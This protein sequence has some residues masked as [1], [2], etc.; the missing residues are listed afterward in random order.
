LSS[1]IWGKDKN[2]ISLSASKSKNEAILRLDTGDY[3]EIPSEA[4]VLGSPVV[5]KQLS[6]NE[7]SPSMFLKQEFNHSYSRSMEF[8]SSPLINKQPLSKNVKDPNEI[9]NKILG[10]SENI[11][12]SIRDEEE[13]KDSKMVSQVNPNIDIDE[14]NNDIKEIHKY[15]EHKKDV[16]KT[17]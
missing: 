2:S 13:K 14:W 3:L 7:T 6:T 1:F 15:V 11:S 17:E 9:F 10:D 8:G 5:S 4:K 16:I 12:K